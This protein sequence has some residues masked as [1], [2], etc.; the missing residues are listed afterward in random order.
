MAQHLADA[1]VRLRRARLQAHRLAELSERVLPAVGIA[2]YWCAEHDAVNEAV[3]PGLHLGGY[4]FWLGNNSKRFEHIAVDE[5]PH[6]HPL[7]LL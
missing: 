1:E 3:I 7:A 4:G 2:A 6:L 5:F